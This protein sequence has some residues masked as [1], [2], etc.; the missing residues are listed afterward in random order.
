MKMK[1]KKVT[2]KLTV[3]ELIGLMGAVDAV[4]GNLGWV[5]EA[6]RFRSSTRIGC[7]R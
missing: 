6:G 7:I 5:A 4:L 3:G 1:E 2:V